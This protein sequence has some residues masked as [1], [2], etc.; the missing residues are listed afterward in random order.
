MMSNKL[1][2]RKTIIFF[3][4]AESTIIDLMIEMI[5]VSDKKVLFVYS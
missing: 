1:A 5:A 4:P 3:Y 2:Q